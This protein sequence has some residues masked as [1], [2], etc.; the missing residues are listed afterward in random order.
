MSK[1]SETKQNAIKFLNFTLWNAELY[2]VI[3][4]HNQG[5]EIL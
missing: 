4:Y 1:S 5:D 2:Y 3:H